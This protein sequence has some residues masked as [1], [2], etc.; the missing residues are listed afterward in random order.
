MAYIDLA[1]TIWPKWIIT[2]PTPI[3]AFSQNQYSNLK[4][5]R[6]RPH[7]IAHVTAGGINVVPD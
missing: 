6:R 3:E 7:R 2:V 1:K 5:E 4:P